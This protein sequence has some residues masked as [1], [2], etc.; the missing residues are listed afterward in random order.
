MRWSRPGPAVQDDQRIAARRA[1]RRAV[2][3][4]R[5]AMSLPLMR[6]RSYATAVAAKTPLVVVVTGP[7]AS[8]K[9]TIA[10]AR[11]RG[12]AGAAAREGPDQGGALRR[13]RHGRPRV[14][15]Q[16]RNRDL[17]DPLPDARAGAAGRP[18][19][20]ARGELRPQRGVRPVERDPAEASLPRAAD[21]LH[22]RPR[23]AARTLR[24]PLRLTPSGPHRRRTARGRDRVD[25]RRPLARPRAGGR[26][27][28]GRHDG[29]E[30]R[31]RGR[32]WWSG[33]PRCSDARARQR[34]PLAAERDDGPRGRPGRL[35][36]GGSAPRSAERGELG[37]PVASPAAATRWAGSSS[38]RGGLLLDTRPL[39]RV[40]GFDA[41]ARDRRGR[42]R[43]PVAGAARV[44]AP[45]A[46]GL[47]AEADRS[48]P[49]LARRR[50]RR[51]RPRP[52]A[53][54]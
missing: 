10:R 35:A 36:R 39:A 24:R 3:C 38:A 22:R 6:L 26:A 41:E 31:R 49:A 5:R 1:R 20:R 29:L 44:P 21:R 27:G 52:R 15:A 34:H 40:L 16:A 47:P 48:R 7:P 50:A 13:A 11:R 42:G 23:D 2:A 53:R 43:D 32:S 45:D 4:R 33:R 37:V 19:L 54:R 25:R 17:R 51:E 8:G 18:L 9:S 28:R 46:L 12:P 14:V 30:R